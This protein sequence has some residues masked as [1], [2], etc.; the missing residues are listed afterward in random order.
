M[1]LACVANKILVLSMNAYRSAINTNKRVKCVTLIVA[2]IQKRM[3]MG[4]NQCPSVHHQYIRDREV[5]TGSPSSP[6]AIAIS[7]LRII[8]RSHCISIPRTRHHLL[9]ARLLYILLTRLLGVD[10]SRL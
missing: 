5:E 7:V 10:C 2:P 4:A 3:T 8:A 1:V 9:S 6:Y